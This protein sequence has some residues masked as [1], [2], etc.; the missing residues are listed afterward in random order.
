M[1]DKQYIEKYWRI[2][3]TVLMA[4]SVFC[5]WAFIKPYLLLAREQ[6]QLFLM[7]QEY[8]ITRISVPGGLAQYIGEMLVQFFIQP[9]YGALIYAF[10]FMFV[11][12]LVWRIICRE[13]K[14]KRDSLL[15][16][17]ISFIPSFVLLWLSTDLYIPMT[18]IIGFIIS[19]VVISCLPVHSTYR[20][21]W[22]L[23]FI[24]I[25]YWLLGPIVALTF[26]T[27]KFKTVNFS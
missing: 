6:S 24:T 25:G 27:S 3:L 14:E 20:F 15:L 26:V 23:G 18:S 5:Y 11:Q 8:F 22:I 19:L 12:I 2:G 21:L 4:I 16:W 17:L 10:I 1:T 13:R 9:F 7:C